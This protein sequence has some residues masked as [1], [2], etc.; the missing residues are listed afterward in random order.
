MAGPGWPSCRTSTSGAPRSDSLFSQVEVQ[1]ILVGANSYAFPPQTCWK[2]H[3]CSRTWWRGAAE[4]GGAPGGK[5]GILRAQAGAG[6]RGRGWGRDMLLDRGG[7][8]GEF[9]EKQ[10]TEVPRR[11]TGSSRF[12]ENA[13]IFVIFFLFSACSERYWPVWESSTMWQAL[14]IA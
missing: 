4:A 6:G 11:K 7:G 5:S 12:V 3:Q 10:C 13:H 1:S 9:G 14:W 2:L 8:K